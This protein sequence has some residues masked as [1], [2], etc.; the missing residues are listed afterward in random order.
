VGVAA[1]S[2]GQKDTLIAD[3]DAA[4]YTAK[5]RGKNRTVKAEPAAANVVGGE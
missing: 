1:S 3:A 5:R 4:L 2:D